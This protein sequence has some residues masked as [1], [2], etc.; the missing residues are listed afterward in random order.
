MDLEWDDENVE[1][2]ARH[3]ITPWEVEEAVA[4]SRRTAFPAHSGRA[5]VIGRT[6][7]GRILVV[8]VEQHTLMWHVVTAR[9][10]TERERRLYRRRTR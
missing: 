6:E 7:A 3:G 8:I 2:V 1:H 4:D 9:Q 10:A 5:G